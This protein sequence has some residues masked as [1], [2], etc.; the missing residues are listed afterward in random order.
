LSVDVEIG[1]VSA[2]VRAVDGSHL[3]SPEV[4]KEIVRV[5]LHAVEER[6]AHT[7]RVRAERRVTGGVSQERDTEGQP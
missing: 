2:T 3:L 6:D 1:E 4:L 5:V 7:E